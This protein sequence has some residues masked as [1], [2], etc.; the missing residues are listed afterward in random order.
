[1]WLLVTFICFVS[2]LLLRLRYSVKIKG[3]HLLTKEALNKKDGILFLPNHPAHI[4]PLLLTVHLWPNFKLR[5]IVVEY[6]FRQSG[7]NLIMRLIRALSMPNFDTSLNEIKLKK[8]KQTID[9]IIQGVKKKD[10]FLIYPSGRLKHT[11]REILGGSSATH[12]ILKACPDANVVLIRTT[13]LWGSSFSRAYTGSS[14]DFKTMAVRGV[15]CLLKSFI[16]FMPRRKVLIEMMPAP[17]DFPWE[18][19]RLDVNKYLEKWYNNYPTTEGLVSTEPPNLVSYSPFKEQLL[20]LPRMEAKTKIGQ[21]EFSSTLEEE[22]YTELARIAKMPADKVRPRMNLAQ[23][24]GLDSLDIS[25]VITFLSVNYDVSAVHPEDIETVQDVLEVADG[26]KKIVLKVLEEIS[27]YKWPDEKNRP[28]PL[29][30]Q[31]KIIQEAFLNVCDRL[32]NYPAIADDVSGVLTYK[33]LKISALLLASEIKKYPSKHVAILL[34]ASVGTYLVIL[35]TLLANKIPVMLNWTLGPRY[36]NHMMQVTNSDSVVSSWKFLEKLSNVEFGHLTKKIHYLEDIKKKISKKKKFLGLLKS[37]KSTK[38]LLK[39]LDLDKISENDECVILFTSGTEAAPKGVPLSHK[40][41]LSNQTAALQCANL[42]SYETFY[43]ILPPFHSFGFSVAGLLPILA[44]L[45]IAFYPDPTDSYSLV[46]GIERW[47]ITLVCSAPSFLKGILQAGTKEQF[48]SM[49]LFVTG[50]EKTPKE[51]SEKISKLDEGKQLIEGYGITE[52]APIISLNRPNEEHVGVGKVLPGIEI[53]IINPETEEV[54]DSSKEGEL[55]V[56]GPNVFNGYIAIDRNP[57]IEINGEK[58]YRTGDL[59]YLDPKGNII[60]SGRLKR[61]AKVAGEMVSLGAI[62][63]VILD[64]ILT[65]TKM[66]AEGPIV[67]VCATETE[68]RRPS[69]VLF[70]I[71]TLNKNEANMILKEAGFSNLV[72]ISDVKII[73]KIPLMGTGK[74]DYRFLQSMIE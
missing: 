21:R 18:G 66:Q 37:M 64:E 60:I 44:G 3:R 8:A 63:E 45:K 42:V 62:E 39:A 48:K 13:G 50:A 72:K 35:A 7:I 11:G 61:F 25:E 14:P 34:P 2:R 47:K 68:G 20:K 53:T 58:W 30:P 33:K 4:D 57:F 6:I 10:N 9:D 69:L 59:G 49:R 32:K 70:T 67:A 17:V 41:I 52:C 28:N 56:K 15:K 40:N 71:A 46:E 27:V 31:G 29:A 43:G 12:T 51:I 24:L 16:F 26:T 5:P 74:I 65:R 73:D 1:R 36:L 23:D 19:T 38:S 22:V 55:C 54:L